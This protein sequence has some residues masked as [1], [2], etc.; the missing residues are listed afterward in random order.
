M[1]LIDSIY[2]ATICHSNSIAHLAL[3][4]AYKARSS[5][6]S[7]SSTPQSGTVWNI[8]NKERKKERKNHPCFN[9]IFPP[10]L[11]GQDSENID[12]ARW[13]FPQTIKLN[14]P[15]NNFTR[16]LNGGPPDLRWNTQGL[17]GATIWR[18]NLSRRCLNE[19]KNIFNQIINVQ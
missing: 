9:F 19:N 7:A 10:L 2:R 12:W 18:N 13:H 6:S 16:A 1:N 17:P 3:L 14:K 8:I 11:T 15:S 5:L 4:S